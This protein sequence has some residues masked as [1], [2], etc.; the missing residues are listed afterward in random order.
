MGVLP[1]ELAGVRRAELNLDGSE[2]FDVTGLSAGPGPR[3]RGRLHVR[4]ASGATDGFDVV[5]RIDTAEEIACYT[6]GGILPMV[7]REFLQTR[8]AP[9]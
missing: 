4:R 2:T 1:L 3:S 7:Y 6:H 9:T 5:I 8:A